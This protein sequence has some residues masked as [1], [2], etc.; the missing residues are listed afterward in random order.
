MPQNMFRT[1]RCKHDKKCSKKYCVFAHTV[2]ELQ[3]KYV[4]PFYK[5]L[6]CKYYPNCSM[7]YSCNYIH[8]DDC[9]VFV[10]VHCQSCAYRINNGYVIGKIYRGYK[11]DHVCNCFSTDILRTLYL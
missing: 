7:S 8:M 2:D 6:T 10:N 9:L 3:I 5:T 4:S 11:K 1:L